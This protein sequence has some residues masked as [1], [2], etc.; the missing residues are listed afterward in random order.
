[1]DL[2]PWGNE[3]LKQL[4]QKTRLPSWTAHENIFKKILLKLQRKSR[5]NRI[6]MSS[7]SPLHHEAWFSSKNCKNI[8]VYG[9]KWIICKWP[10][11][12]FSPHPLIPGGG[13]LGGGQYADTHTQTHNLPVCLVLL[14]GIACSVTRQYSDRKLIKWRENGALEPG[15]VAP[16]SHSGFHNVIQGS[17]KLSSAPPLKTIL[18]L[19]IS[20]Q[21]S[22]FQ[23]NK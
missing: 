21:K 11:I 17:K 2:I 13:G 6:K 4:A 16:I 10:K 14:S 19:I 5:Q 22:T 23:K 1:M 15:P 7:R 12:G 20:Q 9:S 3:N 8:K 18:L